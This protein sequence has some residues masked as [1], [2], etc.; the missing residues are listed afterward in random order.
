[1]VNPD[2]SSW[3]SE[4]KCYR[5]TGRRRVSRLGLSLTVNLL[6][7]CS[8]SW[9]LQFRQPQVSSVAGPRNQIRKNAAASPLRRFCLCGPD[10]A[11]QLPALAPFHAGAFILVVG[12]QDRAFCLADLAETDISETTEEVRGG[13]L[14]QHEIERC[15]LRRGDEVRNADEPA[16]FGVPFAIG[17]IGTFVAKQAAD[18]MYARLF[19]K[20]DR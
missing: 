20:K 1:M 11:Q 16:R 13:A 19:I 2:A 18:D 3:S 9:N 15:V 8:H 10:V 12:H 14:L 17:E 7:S 4:T 6:K 5:L